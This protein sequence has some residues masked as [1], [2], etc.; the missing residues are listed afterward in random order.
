MPIKPNVLERTAFFTLNTAPG[1]MLDLAGMLGYQALSTAV[2]LNIF[3]AL[4]EQ[5]GGAAELAARLGAQPRGLERLLPALESLGYLERQNGRYTNSAMTRK[6]FLEDA[7]LDMVSAVTC[8][9]YF[10]RHLWPEAPSVVSSGERPFDFYGIMDA[11]P[12]L[13]HAFQQMMVGNAKIAGA[14][15]RGHVPVPD[16]ATRLLDVGG[17]H[18][19]FA[20]QFCAAHPRLLA[21]IMDTA[22]AL[23][24]ARQRVAAAGLSTR[25]TLRAADLW[26]EP[27]GGP[28]DLILLFNLLHHYDLQT[29]RRLLRHAQNALRPGGRVAILDQV[30]GNVFGTAGG[31]IVDLVALMYFLFADGRVFE[32]SDLTTLLTESG[33]DQTAVHRLRRAPGSSL[34]T[35]VRA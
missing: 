11:D 4:A 7:G 18:G 26:Q 2:H 27:W 9:D 15:I 35:A 17:G 10:T 29:N 23:N 5:P 28:Y 13:S 21:Q 25:I 22:V 8:F 24:T 19:E 12:E 31:A 34:I 1:P 3:E 6:W 32:I 14:E 20:I 16:D 33:F 30:Q